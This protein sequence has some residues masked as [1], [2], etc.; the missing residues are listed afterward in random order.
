LRRSQ[1]RKVGAGTSI[2]R[3][4]ESPAKKLEGDNRMESTGMLGM[5]GGDE[6]RLIQESFTLARGRTLVFDWAPIQ[7]EADPDNY[8]TPTLQATHLVGR[9]RR[10]CMNCRCTSLR[11]T[12]GLG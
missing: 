5:R 2:G 8:V 6:A 3:R 11:R 9:K 12:Y 4:P 1:E 10:S 7:E